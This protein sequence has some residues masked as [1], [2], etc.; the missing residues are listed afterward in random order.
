MEFRRCVLCSL[1][2]AVVLAG[3]ALAQSQPPITIDKVMT[4]E[5]L[6]AT[7]VESLTSAQR[8]ALDKWLSDY[9]LRV[10]QVAKDE[11]PAVTGTGTPPATYA[12]GSG[13]HWIR[14][15]ANDGAIIILEDGS[16]WGINS[17]DRIDTML[18]L[19]ISNITILKASPSVG[20]YKYSLINTDDKE[21]ALAKY[22]G[23]Q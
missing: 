4:G 2:F 6:H 15:K 10:F 9:T 11:K 14:S 16:M 18:W 12:G 3:L 17:L 21:K 20:D 22:L 5:E 7:G 13:G 8:S 23:K 19:P 1:G